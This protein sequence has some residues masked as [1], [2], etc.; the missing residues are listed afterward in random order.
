MVAL[1]DSFFT[2]QHCGA[3]LKFNKLAEIGNP[4]NL[5]PSECQTVANY[6]IDRKKAGQFRSFWVS[7]DE[8]V[9]LLVN[10]EVAAETAW[11]PAAKEARKQGAPVE[12][13]WT[14]EGYDKWM[15]NAF[16]PKEAE[17]RGNLEQIYAALDWFLGGAYAAQIATLRGYVT[18]RSDLAK[19]YAASAGWTPAQIAEID[20][21]R[22]KL[23]KKFAHELFWNSG[24]PDDISAYEREMARFKNA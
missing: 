23:E 10:R 22:T 11:E 13:A 18:P 2:L 6:L 5:T 1:D 4:G 7:Y 12:Y 16:I 20:E 17:A 14:I 9:S 21:T 24:W 19:G 15:I 8:Q 3:Y